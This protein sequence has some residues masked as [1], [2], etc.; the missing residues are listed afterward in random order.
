L[1][2]P[3][4]SGFGLFMALLRKADL[5]IGFCQQKPWKAQSRIG[6]ALSL[7]GECDAFVRQEAKRS[8]AAAK[9]ADECFAFAWT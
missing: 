6:P 5:R 2:A 3:R 7:P 8:E 4:G 1:T 9:P